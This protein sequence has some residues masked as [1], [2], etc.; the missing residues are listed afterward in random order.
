MVGTWI[1]KAET[2]ALLLVHEPLVNSAWTIHRYLIHFRLNQVGDVYKMMVRVRE[3][4][5]DHDEHSWELVMYYLIFLIPDQMWLL[6][7]W[8]TVN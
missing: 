6:P 7:H 2:L 1:L 3:M 5:M 8:G 4:S